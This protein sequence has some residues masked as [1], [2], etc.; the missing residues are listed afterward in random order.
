[1][2]NWGLITF[3]E[4]NVLFDPRLTSSATKQRVTLVVAHE[5]GHFWFGNLVTMVR[6]TYYLCLLC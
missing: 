6:L 3:R 5:V 2:E 4:V 1:M